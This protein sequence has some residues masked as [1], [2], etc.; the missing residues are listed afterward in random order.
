MPLPAAS[1]RPTPSDLRRAR[2]AACVRTLALTPPAFLRGHLSPEG[3]RPPPRS[4]TRST[5]E[6]HPWQEDL[7]QVLNCMQGRRRPDHTAGR[8]KISHGSSI[9]HAA[10]PREYSAAVAVTVLHYPGVCLPSFAAAMAGPHQISLDSRAGLAPAPSPRPGTSRRLCRDRSDHRQSRL[11]VGWRQGMVGGLVEV[12]A[13]DV[14]RGKQCRSA[15]SW[16]WKGCCRDQVRTFKVCG[17]DR[18]G[19]AALAPG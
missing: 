17:L 7:A 19:Q 12:D 9:A 1:G 5:N 3:L 13:R 4:T 11:P 6:L 14:C 8:N 10:E 18:D 15:S 2:P 16:P